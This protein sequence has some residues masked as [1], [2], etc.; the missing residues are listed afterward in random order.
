M[1]E[2]LQAILSPKAMQELDQCILRYPKE[3]KRSAVLEALHLVQE[4]QG[5]SLTLPAMDA[6]AHYL[7]MP[8]IAVYEI[9][10]FY[11]MFELKP[12]GKHVLQLCTNISCNL[13]G[14]QQLLA[15][16]KQRLGIEVGETTADG[17]FTLREVE[18][19]GACV[20]APVC[21]IGKQYYEELNIEKIDEII[22]RLRG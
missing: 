14:A 18:C 16:I 2:A 5:G 7:E 9:A 3:Q 12:V 11:S 6:V 17:Q 8:A 1:N 15:H 4:E 13:T 21:Q 10:A 22:T 20:S 19:L